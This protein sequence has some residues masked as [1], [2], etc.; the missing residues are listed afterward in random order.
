MAHAI[1][2]RKRGQDDELC[3]DDEEAAYI[4]SR[5]HCAALE[6]KEDELSAEGRGDILARKLPDAVSL[7]S[8]TLSVRVW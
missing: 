7:L 3:A 8:P 4:S 6:V 1:K 5:R 2:K